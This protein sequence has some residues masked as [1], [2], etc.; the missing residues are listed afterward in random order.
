[1]AKSDGLFLIFI[2]GLIDAFWIYYS[3]FTLFDLI[4]FFAGLGGIMAMFII[5][6]GYELENKNL[7]AS[8]YLISG[9]IYAFI[10]YL[11]Y[12]I[13]PEDIF[14]FISL[15]GLIFLAISAIAISGA[16]LIFYGYRLLSY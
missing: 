12:S 11:G 1:M 9:S 16:F 13:H 4:N 14:P 6:W 15:N 3:L 10:L 7:Q 2:G 5:I 8:L